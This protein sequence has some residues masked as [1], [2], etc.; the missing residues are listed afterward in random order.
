[1]VDQWRVALPT[2]REIAMHMSGWRLA[3][4]ETMVVVGTRDSRAVMMECR[5][6]GA[7]LEHA[8]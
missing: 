7:C 2:R 5:D 3:V 8:V 4:D 1:M 6:W